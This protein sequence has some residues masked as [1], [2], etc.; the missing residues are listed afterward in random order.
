MTLRRL[1][2]GETTLAKERGYDPAA[3]SAL[4]H[5]AIILWANGCE[6]DALLL[7]RGLR[8][9]EPLHPETL[10]LLGQLLLQRGASAEALEYFAEA[11][12]QR[13]SDPGLRVARAL[14]RM[15][16]SDIAG[17]VTDLEIAGDDPRSPFGRHARLLLEKIAT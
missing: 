17:A 13:P 15:Q 5:D 7:L 11:L 6:D 3:L 14:V 1:L 8:A 9:L 2:D 4:R 10:R 16:V 12:A